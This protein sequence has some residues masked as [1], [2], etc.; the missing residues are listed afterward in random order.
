MTLSQ[1]KLIA[2]IRSRGGD[3]AWNE[4]STFRWRSVEPLIR[5]GFLRRI[6]CG[7]CLGCEFGK[8]HGEDWHC[9]KQHIRLVS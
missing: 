4:I 5:A 9:E 3:V 7:T 1:Q 2:L 8:R 6:S